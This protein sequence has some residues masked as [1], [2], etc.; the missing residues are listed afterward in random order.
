LLAVIRNDFEAIHRSY[1]FKPE[2]RVPVPGHPELSVPYKK[3]VVMERKSV[4]EFTEVVGDDVVELDVTALLNGVDLEGAR[5][6][7]PAAKEPTRAI[8]LFYS[9]AHKDEELRDELETHLKLFQRQG[10][11]EPWH[12][13]RIGAGS[14]W[15]GEID[16]NLERADAILLLVS[17]DFIASD[18]CYDKEMTRALE[19]HGEGATRVIPII[20]RDCNWRSAP[21]AELQA[22]PTDARPVPTWGPDKYARD[23]AW[24]NVADGIEKVLRELLKEK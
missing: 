18:Y 16:D 6:R 17:A 19:R 23:S 10:L 11:I 14:E 2:E 15:K 8:R 1:K 7:E 5:R 20:I 9:Y 12:D 4:T 22:L 24:K 21:F 3:L 13:R